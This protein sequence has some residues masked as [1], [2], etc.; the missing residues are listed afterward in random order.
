M[1]KANVQWEDQGLFFLSRLINMGSYPERAESCVVWV[2][3]SP[4]MTS[5]KTTFE[6]IKI[7]Q[8]PNI[9]RC[10]PIKSHHHTQSRSKKQPLNVP[11]SLPILPREPHTWPRLCFLEV[12]VTFLLGRTT[13][14]GSS[15]VLI[16]LSEHNTGLASSTRPICVLGS[17]AARC[18]EPV[19]QNILLFSTWSYWSFHSLQL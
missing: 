18:V 14:P 16:V 10:S 9:L 7:S 6:L 11:H 15:V 3:I 8:I 4:A 2:E 5:R 1:F 19:L 17:A 13:I 12:S